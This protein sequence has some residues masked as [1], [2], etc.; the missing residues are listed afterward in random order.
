LRILL[1]RDNIRGYESTLGGGCESLI[2]R[3]RWIRKGDA[4]REP[5]KRAERR[6][7]YERNPS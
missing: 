1:D 6:N 3:K 4:G 5:P 7:V 2:M